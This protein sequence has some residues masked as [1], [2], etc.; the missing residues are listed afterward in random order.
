[1]CGAFR[2][3]KAKIHIN[4]LIKIAI[5]NVFLAGGIGSLRMGEEIN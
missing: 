2:A 1:M 3:V 5:L 4:F